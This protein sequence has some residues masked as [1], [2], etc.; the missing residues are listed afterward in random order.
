MALMT[1]FRCPGGNQR[2]EAFLVGG[3][4]RVVP[5]DGSHRTPP[6]EAFAL[7]VEGS[8]ATVAAAER[9]LRNNGVQEADSAL[10]RS[11]ETARLC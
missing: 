4:L 1:D 10:W 5:R 6:A 9:A 2:L 11:A 3:R 8:Y 7:M